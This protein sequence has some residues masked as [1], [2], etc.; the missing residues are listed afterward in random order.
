MNSYQTLSAYYDRF[1]DDVGYGQW[2]EFFR[3]AFL[4][5]RTSGRSW[6]SIWPAARACSARFW[7]EMVS[8]P[9]E[10]I[11]P[12]G[13]IEIA[14]Q[15]N[16]EISYEV[17]DMITYRPDEKFDL[18]TCTGDALN[19]IMRLEDMDRIFANVSAYLAEGG[20]FIFDILNEK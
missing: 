4:R 6:C 11:F 18:V 16:P 13:M 19:H 9:V 15:R 17:A 5:G 20:Y 3:A 1:T 8:R 12:E 10:W 14:K 2:A 7:R